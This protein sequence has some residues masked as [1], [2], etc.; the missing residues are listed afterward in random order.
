MA[1]EKTEAP[2]G[3]LYHLATLRKAD[4]FKQ[5]P[6]EDAV[7]SHAYEPEDEFTQWYV[8][9]QA[10]GQLLMPPYLPASLIRLCQENNTLGPCVDAMVT[11]CDGTGFDFEADDNKANDHT[12]DSTIE[13]LKEF[14]HEPWPG[15]SFLTQRQELRRDLERTGNAYLEVLRNIAGEIVF[16]RRIDAKMMR[17]VKLDEAVP[18]VKKLRRRG[19]DVEV[20][21]MMRERRFVQLLNGVTLVYFKE[22]GAS[23][24]LNKRTGN[25]A[26][27]TE[28]LD[29][30]LRA[31]EIIHFTVNIDA[32]TPYGVPRWVGQMPSVLGSRKAEEF[33]L[34]FFDNGGIPPALIILEGGTL[35]S[36]ARKALEQKVV[37]GPAKDK[38]RIQILE[39][40]ATGG[41]WEKVATARVTVERF[42]DAGSQD[43]M[44]E[45]YDDKCEVRVR[46]SFRLPP[47]F[48]GA[49]QDYAFASAVASYTVAE[50]QVFKPERDEFDEII[51]MKLLPALGYEGYR[52]KSK[53]LVIEDATLKLQGIETAISTQAVD[54]EDVIGEINDATG[55]N[56][57]YKE[58]PAPQTGAL[59]ANGNP[60]P[61]VT[62]AATDQGAPAPS[63]LKEPGTGG[64]ANAPQPPK[65]PG[66]NA[67]QKLQ[68]S[69]SDGVISLAFEAMGDL[70]RRD[71]VSLAKDLD[72]ARGLEPNDQQSFRKACAELQF[73]NPDVDLDGLAALM[74]RTIG[75]MT[76]DHHTH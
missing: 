12:D 67:P 2:K 35:V 43:S 66:V 10:N 75:V 53:P 32:Y 47:I 3:Q 64:S 9:G 8:G 27:A 37:F 17:I 31:T 40:E 41:T 23:R 33:N 76:C 42:G 46:R 18:V 14:F 7:G 22:F 13:A 6:P 65:V 62:Q 61:A 50:A 29:A 16:L 55:T 58:P 56:L 25:W 49:A 21:V 1:D 20:T 74:G 60:L 63:K 30:A 11:N 26:K 57:K 59:D 4:P 28:Q 5:A 69:F 24:E 71:M 51:S 39:V 54:M 15:E 34:D 38:N 70:R 73:V 52:M 36:E 45:K 48:V 44:F 68:K 72:L 19:V